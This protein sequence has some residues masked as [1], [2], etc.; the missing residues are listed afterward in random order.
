MFKR[1][2]C[3]CIGFVVNGGAVDPDDK[4]IW[5]VRA[6]DSGCRDPEYG[7]RYSVGRSSSLA[8]K[9]GVKLSDEQVEEI[10]SDLGSLIADGYR[11]RSLRD[12]L[13]S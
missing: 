13:R 1:Y 5:F 3:G 4:R 8:H 10:L 12:L 2:E 11:F 6:C 7:F 9:P